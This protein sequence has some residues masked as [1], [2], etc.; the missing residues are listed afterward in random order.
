MPLPFVP[1]CTPKTTAR[2]PLG[3]A[4]QTEPKLD[5]FR[6]QVVKD[7]QNVRLFTRRGADWSRRVPALTASL[8]A[9]PARTAIL[10]CELIFLSETGD[11]ECNQLLFGLDQICDGLN[12]FAFDLL[13]LDGR[14]LTHKPLIERRRQLVSLIETSDIPCLHLVAAF[15][16]AVALFLAVDK[17]GLEG[18]VCKRKDAPYRSG[19]CSDWLKMKT[20]KW[21]RA[22]IRRWQMFEKW[23]NKSRTRKRP[24]RGDAAASP[25]YHHGPSLRERARRMKAS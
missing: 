10:D 2:L 23:R 13:H 4:W 20:Q 25:P 14:D 17:M 9:I 19:P 3:D 12:V 22:N 24:P 5:G 15:E 6:L 21:L 7:R 1:P 11:I 16:D 8:A 18:V